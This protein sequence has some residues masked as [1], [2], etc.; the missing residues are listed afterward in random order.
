MTSAADSPVPTAGLPEEVDVAVVGAGFAGLGAALRLARRTETYA[1]L[2]RADD[3]GGTW[4][5]NRYPG[6]GCDVPS[7]LY[8]Y[9]EQRTGVA[10]GDWSRVFARGGEIH[11]YL[12]RAAADAGVLPHVHLRTEVL[13]AAW[14]DGRW[15]LRLRQRGAGDGAR[16]RE[17]VAR[18]LVMAVGRLSE[19]RWPEVPGLRDPRPGGLRAVHTSDWPTDL[20][21]AGLRVG[22]VGTGATAAQL[23]PA[24]AGRAA[25]VVVLQRTPAYVVPRGDQAYDAAER[26]A[27]RAPGAAGAL[28]ERLFAEQDRGVAARLAPGPA[29][30]ELRARALD[31]LA[32]QVADPGLRAL[33]TPAY[34]VGC[35]RVVLSDDWYPALQRDDVTLEP[36]ALVRVEGDRVVAASG[37]EHA[38]DLLVLATGFASTEPPFA[39]RVAGRGARRLAEHW[40]R[41][42]VAY[43]STTVHG[44]PNLFVLDGPN[45]SLGH[46]SVVD[47]IETQVAYVLGALDR[48]ATD[49]ALALEPT[50]TAE[51]AYVAEID[52]RS[53]GTVWLTGGC[54][55]WYV[56]ERSGRLTLLWPG[57]SAAFRA[58]LDSFDPDAY[59]AV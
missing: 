6:V 53:R 43:N 15:H 34:E 27:L 18:S 52:R 44:F 38:L 20:D 13:D 1:V 26:A 35:K 40:A 4:Q 10:P 41:G 24:I 45:A 8:S 14:R 3:L 9:S 39:E 12:R 23:V 37:R 33:L 59:A 57:S 11:A 54:R 47:M 42:M 56:D 48:L 2:E 31:H 51:E 16:V 50:A 36:T 25:H 22:V 19:P 58:R 55:S 32:A 49:P 46:H 29:R 28:R 7:H 21:V 17:L 5:A 30:D